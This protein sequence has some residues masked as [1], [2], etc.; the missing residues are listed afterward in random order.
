MKSIDII[1]FKKTLE[2][3]IESQDMPKEV[4][5]MVVKEVY[6][7]VSKASLEEAMKEI[8]EREGETDGQD[9]CV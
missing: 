1:S 4:I 7:D 5:R 6:E 3:F 2:G 8:N 9:E